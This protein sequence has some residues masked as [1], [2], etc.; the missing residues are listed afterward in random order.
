MGEKSDIQAEIIYLFNQYS[1]HFWLHALLFTVHRGVG[2]NTAELKKQP[3]YSQVNYR[4]RSHMSTN[5]NMS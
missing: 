2:H 1:S 3:S 5:F 4:I